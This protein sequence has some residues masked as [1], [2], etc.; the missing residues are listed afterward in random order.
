ME[1][2]KIIKEEFGTVKRYCVRKKWEY[3]YF[4][5]QKHLGFRTKT[6]QKMLETLWNDGLIDEETYN[7]YKKEKN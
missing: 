1:I 2:T 5:L 7:K 3:D 6:G 4:L